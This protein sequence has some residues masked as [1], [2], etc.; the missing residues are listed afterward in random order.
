MKKR[1]S[2]GHLSMGHALRQEIIDFIDLENITGSMEV[3]TAAFEARLD[4]IEDDNE[5]LNT[6]I[7]NVSS[8]VSSSLVEIH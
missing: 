1:R 4:V 5:V 7:T 8:S 3:V 6:T 2:L